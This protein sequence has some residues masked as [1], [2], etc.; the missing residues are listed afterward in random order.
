MMRGLA[1]LIVE[2]VVMRGL[3]CLIGQPQS[4]A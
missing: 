3:A 4:R 2:V 1:Y